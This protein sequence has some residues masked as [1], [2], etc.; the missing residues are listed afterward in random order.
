MTEPKPDPETQELPR[1]LKGAETEQLIQ[2]LVEALSKPPDTRVVGE[3]AVKVDSL[4]WQLLWV[5]KTLLSMKLN[6]DVS[7]SEVVRRLVAKYLECIIQS[8]I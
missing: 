2:L 6:R 8:A 1:E 7:M 4:T 3:K 5:L